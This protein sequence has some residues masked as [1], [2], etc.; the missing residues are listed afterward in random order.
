MKTIP[1]FNRYMINE[2]GDVYSCITG[3]GKK[4][5]NSG[6]PQRKL[7]PILDSTGYYIVTLTDGKIK[8]NRSIHRLLAKQYIPNPLNLPHVNHIDGD[9]TNNS[10]SN[11]EWV[12]VLE[13]TQHA[14]RIGLTDPK[15]KERCPNMEE[16]VQ[17]YLNS[18]IEIARFPSIHEAGRRNNIA[19]QNISKV[20]RGI[21]KNAG[22]FHWKY[23]SNV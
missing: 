17:Y 18:D 13:N 21:R 2:D 10:L 23:A 8:R 20:V 7:K 1:E 11:L 9:K 6:V 4:A 12:T 15:S 22:G 19:Y 5:I 3:R 14:I 16:V